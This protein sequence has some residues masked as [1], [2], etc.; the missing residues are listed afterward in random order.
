[1]ILVF[2]C[3]YA[4]LLLFWYAY[5]ASSLLFFHMPIR[6]TFYTFCMLLHSLFICRLGCSDSDLVCAFH[7]PTFLMF[8]MPLFLLFSLVLL[9]MMNN[10]LAMI[11]WPRS[12]Y[13]FLCLVS[14]LFVPPFSP[15]LSH[16][17]YDW[18]VADMNYDLRPL[19]CTFS[20]CD[21]LLLRH[22]LLLLGFVGSIAF[23]ICMFGGE[24]QGIFVLRPNLFFIWQCLFVLPCRLLMLLQGRLC[25]YSDFCY[26]LEIGEAFSLFY[27]SLR[28]TKG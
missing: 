8:Y 20:A 12:V 13:S 17:Y 7:M 15:L 6:C 22:V 4:L 26:H 1:M 25:S 16:S 18:L 9:P 24:E 10:M 3:L 28:M 2:I 11:K 5:V 19:S 21:A 14:I 27:V 23:I